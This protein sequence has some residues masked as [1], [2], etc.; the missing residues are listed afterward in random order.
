MSFNYSHIPSNTITPLLSVLLGKP[1]QFDDTNYFTWSLS[2]R[3]HLYRL[4]PNIWNIIEVG[5]ELPNSDDENFQQ[6]ESRANDPLQ[7]LSCYGVSL[8][9]Q[10]RRVRQ[11]GLIG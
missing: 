10:L 7:C 3:G 1:P 11:G 5:I 6:I 8:I 9:S 4:H 2:M